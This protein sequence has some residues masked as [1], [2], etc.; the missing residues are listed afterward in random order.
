MPRP[1]PRVT[2]MM[3]GMKISLLD[4]GAVVKIIERF[5]QGIEGL[6]VTAQKI[7]KKVSFSSFLN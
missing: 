1:D 5:R 4:K 2:R 7:I 6:G 3:T